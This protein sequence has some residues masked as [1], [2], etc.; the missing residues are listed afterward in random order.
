MAFADLVRRQLA[1]VDALVGEL[2]GFGTVALVLD[3]GRRPGGEGR[4]LLWR[5]AG[6][7]ESPAPAA[8]EAV[9]PGL[10]R[11]LGLPQSAELAA[12]PPACAWPA[13]PATVASY[14]ERAPAVRAPAAG[15]EYLESLRSLGYL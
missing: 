3:P 8:P 7:R 15:E 13:P 1:E 12:P 2:A 11:A 14:G 6:C 5:A 4:L 9:A 10:L